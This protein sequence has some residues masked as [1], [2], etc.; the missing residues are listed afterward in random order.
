MN[1]IILRGNWMPEKGITS[2]QQS[3]D[4]LF[5]NHPEKGE[6]ITQILPYQRRNRR[7]KGA[8]SFCAGREG[9][10]T[11]RYIS[12]FTGI[13]S[14]LYCLGLCLR[15]HQ[16]RMRRQ[17]MTLPPSSPPSLFALPRAYVILHVETV[18]SVSVDL[19]EIQEKTNLITS[20][21]RSWILLM[22]SIFT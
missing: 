5:K 17:W 13:S 19:W 12:R 6:R 15:N 10:R 9:A 16:M 2:I 1:L 22:L 14:V 4:F 20:R 18:S 8:R 21:L 11:S 7:K 3:H